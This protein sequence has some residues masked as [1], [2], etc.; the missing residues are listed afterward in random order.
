MAFET[1]LF[2]WHL[3]IGVLFH[4]ELVLPL[5]LENANVPPNFLSQM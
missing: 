5:G 4:K 3:F 2:R 1:Q